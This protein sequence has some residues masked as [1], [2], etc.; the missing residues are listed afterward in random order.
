MNRVVAGLSALVIG[1]SGLVFVSPAASATSA[2]SAVTVVSAKVTKN[3]RAFLKSLRSDAPWLRVV[4][5]ATLI[6]TGKTTCR[7]LRSGATA[8][9]VIDA[10]INA[11]LDDED[12][13]ALIANAVVYYCPAQAYKF[14]D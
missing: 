9:D 5:N 13:V 1:V 12:I 11:G 7:T 6:K 4:D 3:D 10:G 14:A 8:Y 2:Q